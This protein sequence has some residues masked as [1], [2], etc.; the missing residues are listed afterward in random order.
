MPD[1]RGPARR[2]RTPDDLRAVP[3]RARRPPALLGADPLGLSRIDRPPPTTA[4]ARWPR[5]TPAGDLLITQNVDG[6][7]EA[8]GSR[9]CAL[10]GRVA[11]VICLGC[12]RRRPRQRSNSG[13]D[14]E[15][16]LGRGHADLAS[17]PTATSTSSGDRGFVVP[18]CE[19]CGGVLK[20]DVV[21]FGENVPAER[22]ERCYDAV[23][24]LGRADG[25]LLVGGRP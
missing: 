20:P 2:A 18:D 8:A 16:R 6:L 11:D 22:V 5:W 24:A 23:D 19:R 14:R 12:R 9:G 4:T 17:A 3:V 1:Y 10:H 7:H 25:V 13:C 15:P 21:F